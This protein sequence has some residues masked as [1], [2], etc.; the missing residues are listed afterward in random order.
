MRFV[1]DDDKADAEAQRQLE[2]S[3]RTQGF[4]HIEFQFEPIAAALDYEQQVTG[5]E[6]GLV[7]DIGGGTSDFS[8]IRLSPERAKGPTDAPISS[9]RR[10]C[11]SAAPISTGCCR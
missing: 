1:D 8:V 7:A 10:A 6:L 3:V 4:R 9:P 2:G 5:E 11:M